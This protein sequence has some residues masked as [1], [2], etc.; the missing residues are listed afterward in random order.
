MTGPSQ[1]TWVGACSR[2]GVPRRC[3]QGKT[4]YTF[5]Q[6]GLDGRLYVEVMSLQ[7][8]GEVSKWTTPSGVM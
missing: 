5:E 6:C 4:L 2:R 8:D 7:F 1:S 3:I